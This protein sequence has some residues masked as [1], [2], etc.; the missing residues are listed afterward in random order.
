M[1]PSLRKIKRALQIVGPQGGTAVALVV[2]EKIE[3]W[4]GSR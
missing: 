4:Q 1:V 3:R 2:I